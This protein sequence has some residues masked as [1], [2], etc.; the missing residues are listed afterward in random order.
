MALQGC[1]S[2]PR[3]WDVAQTLS[4]ILGLLL[5]NVLLTKIEDIGYCL[6]CLLLQFL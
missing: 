2:S 3:V 1:V 5:T 6:M 4:N